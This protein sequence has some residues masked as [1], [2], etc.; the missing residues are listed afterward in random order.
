[1]K[2]D[3]K[4]T[5]VPYDGIAE[6][7]AQS[8]QT[9]LDRFL[10]ASG[11]FGVLTTVIVMWR[12]RSL[13]I[14]A[15]NTMLNLFSVFLL[16][17]TWIYRRHLRLEIKASVLLVVYFFTAFKNLFLFGPQSES[18][19][20]LCFCCLI[21]VLIFNQKW[22]I[23][24]A[25]FL[26]LIIP[27]RAYLHYSGLYIIDHDY[28][29]LLTTKA[30]WIA[31]YGMFILAASIIIFGVGQFRTELNKNFGMLHSSFIVL[32]S[33][34]SLLKQEIELKNEY[35][36]S[37]LINSRK[38]QSLLD[39]S[40]D[41]V[42]LIDGKGQ[43]MEVNQTVIDILGYS[44]EELKGMSIFQL[45]DERFRKQTI[46]RFN[47]V[48]TGE[49]QPILQEILIVTRDGKTIPTEVN[50]NLIVSDEAVMVLS[51]VRDISFRKQLE[52]EKF[53][54]ALEAEERERERFS[55]D[56]HDDLGPVFSTLNLYLQTLSSKET[57]E[58]KR[59]V[60]NNLSGIVDSAVKQV[61]EI[62]H[63]M[64]PYLL[65]DAGLIEAIRTHLKKFNANGTIQ[66]HFEAPSG[67]KIKFRTNLEIVLYRVFLELLNNTIKHAGATQVK[68]K[69][70]WSAKELLFVYI[71]NG[72][73][74]NPYER[75]EKTGIGLKNIENRLNAVE[76]NVMFRYLNNEMCIEIKVPL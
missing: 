27:V 46:S 53:N 9:I 23:I 70:S 45:V 32:E 13:E 71:D 73:G 20:F 74:F 30:V 29:Q 40:R 31:S 25:L 64:S 38:F 75:T 36:E 61:R 7:V 54:A 65:R 57:D 26:S 24:I 68:I 37:M 51:T 16:L 10:L 43:L 49:A 28:N 48:V 11:I 63:N 47:K 5:E 52:N 34:N 72:K 14:L 62:S 55:K 60:L 76:G 15:V 21:L 69:L 17:I 58:S 59:N 2:P 66:A 33:T 39:G 4:Q 35:G 8:T 44:Q 19:L 6:S 42:L 50:S 22:S 12:D 18:T 67:E 41:G 56:L 1:L 3:T